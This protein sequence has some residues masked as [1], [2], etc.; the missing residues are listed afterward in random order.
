MTSEPL[1]FCWESAAGTAGGAAETKSHT[2][3]TMH[4]HATNRLESSEALILKSLNEGSPA[5]IGGRDEDEQLALLDVT[6]IMS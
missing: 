5:V 4:W 1:A 3:I 2:Y 6:P